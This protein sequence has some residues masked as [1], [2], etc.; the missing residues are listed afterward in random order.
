MSRILILGFI[1]L[2]ILCFLCLTCHRLDIESAL[3]GETSSALSGLGLNDSLF[4]ISGCVVTLEG[5]IASA[6]LRNKLIDQIKA[7]PGICK[8][9]EA[10]L[11]VASTAGV[12]STMAPTAQVAPAT[13]AASAPSLAPGNL[14]YTVEAGRITLFGAV[15]SEA[16]RQS[17]LADAYARWGEAAVDDRLQVLPNTVT[18]G[19][20]TSFAGLL[21]AIKSSGEALDISLEDGAVTVTGGVLSELAR[22]RVLGAVG[23]AMP[24]Y[25]VIDR[26]TLRQA[27]SAV[28]AVQISLDSELRG[29][30]VEFENNSD[31]LTARGRRVLDAL[32]GALEGNDVRVEIFGHTDSTGAAAHNL[33]LSRRRAASSKRYLVSKGLGAARFSTLGHGETLPIADNASEVGRQK[34]RRTEFRVLEER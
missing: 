22:E 23:V 21:D 4:E 24:G 15:P 25:A 32:A 30:V 17:L 16:V 8:V 6:D 33:D 1:A 3:S 27:A 20:P 29:K 18:E 31:Q 13:P 2:A 19:W 26:L 34:N 11:G 9:N 10:A 14:R 28:E 5:D 12:G 7:I